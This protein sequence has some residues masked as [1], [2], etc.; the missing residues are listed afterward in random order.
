M[1]LFLLFIDLLNA[2][3][4][5]I[6]DAGSSGTRLKIYNFNKNK[7]ISELTFQHHILNKNVSKK[8]IHEQTTAEIEQTI[9]DLSKKGSELY[10]D[11]TFSFYG[12][13]GMRSLSQESQDNIINIVKNKLKDKKTHEVKVLS[14][15]DE[16][17]YSL[18]SLE[19]YFPKEDNFNIVD[20]GGKSVQII[21][22]NKSKI[23]IDSLEMGV[24]NSD[25]ALKSDSNNMIKLLSNTNDITLNI[26]NKNKFSNKKNEIII[27][28]T[29]CKIIVDNNAKKYVCD[30]EKVY[31]DFSDK[32]LN[33]NTNSLL[34]GENL[35]IN[36]AF[37]CIDI[38]FNEK[39]IK[40][41]SPANKVFLLSFYEQIID[42][43]S[44][45]TLKKL[46]ENYKKDCEN[47]KDQKC[48]QLY[49]SLK[50]LEKLGVDE[51]IELILINKKYGININWSHGI[52]IEI[53][54]KK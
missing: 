10:P 46:F 1:Y 16:A 42:T 49:Y 44:N 18:K 38:Y 31:N 17:L 5:G 7:L 50:F 47:K 11:I 30:N 53:N 29:E 4:V 20:M 43:S 9:D 15:N 52:A 39:S 21:Y 25:C 26:F 8:G 51:N 48:I 6:F 28:I 13:A 19:Y 36:G 40:K 45:I 34:I 22:K 37:K 35:N 23:E 33:S 32:I 12:T 3:T 14:G 41:H 54:N 2:I 24:V 27:K